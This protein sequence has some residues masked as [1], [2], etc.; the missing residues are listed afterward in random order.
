MSKISDLQKQILELK[1]KLHRLNLECT[2]IQ[3][4]CETM[5]SCNDFEE[6]S[7]KEINSRY[8]EQI[9]KI[10]E[11]ALADAQA[12]T[13]SIEAFFKTTKVR[14]SNFT[15]E[16]DVQ[17]II[18]ELTVE[19]EKKMSK[20]EQL[21]QEIERKELEIENKKQLL[22]YDGKYMAEPV[23]TPDN[24][25]YEKEAAEK[26]GITQY[27]SRSDLQ[28]E[29]KELV[30]EGYISK[31]DV[32]LPQIWQWKANVARY[33]EAGDEDALQKELDNDLSLLTK[34]VKGEETA[35]YLACKE[36]NLK[37]V[38]TLIMRLGITEARRVATDIPS[39]FYLAFNNKNKAIF[40]ELLQLG[41]TAKDI[42][43]EQAP[44]DVNNEFLNGLLLDA[45]QNN[46]EEQVR[47]FLKMGANPNT[48]ENELGN[49]ALHLAAQNGHELIVVE[50]LLQNGA[51]VNEKNNNG[52]TPLHLAVQ[53]GHFSFIKILWNPD[54][55]NEKNNQGNTPL[56][57]AVLNAERDGVEITKL[58]L[59]SAQTLINIVNNENNTALH[60]VA[61][62]AT[63]TADDNRLL[64]WLEMIETLLNHRINTS[65]CNQHGDTFLHLA[66]K[67]ELFNI[68]GILIESDSY[69]GNYQ[70]ITN[71][72][73]QQTLSNARET[74]RKLINRY[75][76]KQSIAKIESLFRNISH[77]VET[78]TSMV[79]TLKDF[80]SEGFKEI[81]HR[82]LELEKIAAQHTEMKELSKDTKECV[83]P[84]ADS[85]STSRT[86][87]MSFFNATGRETTRNLGQ[88]SETEI[89]NLV[90]EAKKIMDLDPEGAQRLQNLI[91]EDKYSELAEI[92]RNARTNNS[93]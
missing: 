64:I 70:D 23:E 30:A 54:T 89:K 48:K 26:L 14:L 45:V 61:L 28:Q 39:S 73:N 49:T 41:I 85:S 60:M 18:A 33:I 36:G 4:K 13:Q 55:V 84:S 8:Q 66:A 29:V 11:K 5:A 52:D 72:I 7:L 15:T 38:Q 83:A 87:A 35:L 24:K 19:R 86:T 67:R 82:L 47:L 74:A 59:D 62:A 77:K 56:H 76:T 21:N 78:L 42:P 3:K 46:S 58:L 53:G 91:N 90:T 43:E 69:L 22:R 63:S 75:Q 20:I 2:I 71:L 93:L 12:E 40:S 6:V 25:I 9:D 27:T 1:P 31:D 17:S 57:L 34:P 50:L 68:A 80:A 16:D 10:K 51:R 92:I 32:Y 79:D 44:I 88:H 37:I 81:Q 65:A